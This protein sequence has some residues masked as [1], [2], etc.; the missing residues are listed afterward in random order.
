MADDG[1]YVDQAT[2]DSRRQAFLRS[3]SPAALT[4]K[5]RCPSG[6]LCTDFTSTCCPVGA[7]RSRQA[8]ITRPSHL[9]SRD[10]QDAD[11]DGF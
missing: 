11:A 3:F 2:G 6:A 4:A 8:R 9:P 5:M 7:P 1:R 10:R